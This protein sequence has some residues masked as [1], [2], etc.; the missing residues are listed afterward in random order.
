[1]ILDFLPLFFKA[2][3]IPMIIVRIV[4][5]FIFLLYNMMKQFS[6]KLHVAVLCRPTFIAIFLDYPIHYD[7]WEANM[8][9]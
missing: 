6:L 2:S 4:L 3:A 1:M 5:K 9:E 7:A 8:R